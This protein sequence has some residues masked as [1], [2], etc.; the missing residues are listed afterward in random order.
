MYISDFIDRHGLVF[1]ARP[2]DV[3]VTADGT[4][5]DV[6]IVRKGGEMQTQ[7]SVG[8]G[9]EFTAVGFLAVMHNSFR[10]L[11]REPGDALETRYGKAVV[12]GLAATR[13]RFK[14]FL[15]ESLFRKFL[16]EVNLARG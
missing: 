1:L 6:R 11:E 9:R 12:D 3:P 4:S 14:A 15:G 10:M 13:D 16:D 2:A 5:L 8:E 7:V